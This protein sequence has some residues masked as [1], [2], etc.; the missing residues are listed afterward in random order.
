MDLDSLTV[1]T[2]VA[3]SLAGLASSLHCFGMCGPLA[4]AAGAV[5]GGSRQ[6]RVVA[7]LHWQGA[8]LVAYGLVGG[9]LGVLG[10]RAAGLVALTT[11]PVLPW[12]LAFL[13]VASAFG[14]GDRLPAVPWVGAARQRLV[15][16]GARFSRPRRAAAFGALTPLLPCGLLY[17][18]L[19]TALVAGTF[20][21]GALVTAAFGAGAVPA[22]A[23]AQAQSAWLRRLPRGSDVALRRVLPVLAATVLVWRAFHTAPDD[24][25]H[26]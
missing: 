16:L 4:C 3:S 22:L 20:T 11:S 18:A 10:A 12:A 8:R 2:V 21:R 7:S 17:G 1:S 25:C 6:E 26:K 24:C 5:P 14:L 23:L 9:L 15:P 13:L 19:A